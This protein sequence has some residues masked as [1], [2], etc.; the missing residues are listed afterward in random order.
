MGV[1]GLIPI[2]AAVA[3]VAQPYKNWE[4][5]MNRRA[6]QTLASMARPGD[7][8]LVTDG[9]DA[10]LKSRR[11]ILEHWVQQSAEVRY[12]ILADAPV[13][14]RWLPD[15]GEVA[16]AASAGRTWLIVHRTGCPGFDEARLR[17]AR[18]RLESRLGPPQVVEFTLT[19]GESITAYHFS[20]PLEI[21]RADPRPASRVVGPWAVRSPEGS[22][23]AR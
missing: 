2:V 12:N 9:L 1:L 5:W 17:D 3:N 22:S 21:P 18:R 7:R 16:L 10:N 8:W 15:P 13:P 14:T 11:A 20:D 6:V 19:R 4:D 23:T